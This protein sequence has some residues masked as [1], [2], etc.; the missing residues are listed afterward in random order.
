[1]SSKLTTFWNYLNVHEVK[2]PIIQRDYAQGRAKESEKRKRFLKS[3]RDAITTDKRLKLD[4]VY[5]T[6]VDKAIQP[7]DGQQRLTTLW[8]LHWYF[9]A[10]AGKLKDVS[11]ILK[12][13][14][15]IS[16]T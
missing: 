1:M 16:I 3:L 9:A 6:D 13:N 7:L 10:K 12:I 5:G 4:F 15:A 14:M 11:N 8:L 2:I